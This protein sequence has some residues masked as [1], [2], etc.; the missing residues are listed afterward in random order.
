MGV[1]SR[2]AKDLAFRRALALSTFGVLGA[3]TAF[4]VAVGAPVVLGVAASGL[5]VLGGTVGL[6]LHIAERRAQRRD[7]LVQPGGL[8][9]A[10][11][12]DGPGVPSD[13]RVVLVVYVAGDERWRQRFGV[14]LPGELERVGRHVWSD[15][16]RLSVEPGW[17]PE[18]ERAIACADGAVVLVSSNLVA[19]RFV[20]DDELAALR[21]RG[22][23]LIFVPVGG[24]ESRELDGLGAVSWGCDPARPLSSLSQ[25]RAMS[26]IVRIARNLATQLPDLARCDGTDQAPNDQRERRVP[27]LKP[28]MRMG[29]L[30]DV[31]PPATGEVERGELREIC[32]ALVGAG[33]GSVGITGRTVGLYGQ[34]GIGKTVLAAAVARDPVV[35]RHFP[36][37][38]YWVT[39]GE[40][41]DIVER[42]LALLARLGAPRPDLRSRAATG[43]ALQEALAE[44]RCLLIGDDV[45]ST[46]DAA[47]F[48]VTDQA[49]QV[50]VLYTSRDERV[51]NDVDSEVQRIDV[52]PEATARGL[53]AQLTNRRVEALP[54]VTD[55]ILEATGRV[56]LAVALV[57]AAIGRGQRDWVHVAEELDFAATTF[58]DH[59]YADV[60]KAMQVALADDPW[61][62]ERYITLAVYPQDERV[63]IEAIARLWSHIKMVSGLTATRELLAELADANLLVLDDDAITFHDLQHEFLLLRIHDMRQAHSDLL[64]A[65]RALPGVAED[66]WRMLPTAEPYIWE[67]LLY[68]LHGAGDG[69]AVRAVAIDLAY[70]AVRCAREGPYAA[71]R[72]AQAAERLFADDAAIRWTADLLTRWGHLVAGHTTPNNVAAT[73]AIRADHPPAPIDVDRLAL[74]TN[75]FL[76]A[77][78]WGLPTPDALL[79]TLDE[80]TDAVQA[81][82]FSPDGLLLATASDDKTVLLWDPATGQKR[83]S[84]Q[85]RTDGVRALVFSPGG[86]LLATASDDSSVRLWNPA[87]GEQQATLSGHTR[88]VRA[89]AFSPDGRLLATASDD[90]TVRLWDPATGQQRRT[91][92][93]HASAVRAVTFS[94]DGRRLATASDDSTVRL[95]D[96]ATGQQWG[97]VNDHVGAVCAVDFSPDGRLLATAGEDTTVMLSERIWNA[98]T[99]P[100]QHTLHG[101]TGGVGS[102]AFS[103]D[104]QLLATASD[105]TTVGLWDPSDGR[106]HRT[107][108]GHARGVRAVA[109]S[110]DGRLLATASD[111]TT[112]RLWDP[113]SP[114]QH[115]ANGPARGVRAVALSRDARLLG[116]V[117]FDERV[118]LWDLLIAAH[119]RTFS[120]HAMEPRVVAFSPKAVRALA[121]SP[122]GRLLA[123][124]EDGGTIRLWDPVTGAEERTLTSAQQ[125]D[126]GHTYA[127][128]TLEVLSFSPDGRLL[129]TVSHVRTLRL[130]HPP[131]VSYDTALRL[132]DPATGQLQRT[133]NGQM[134][135]VR[136]VAFSPNGR[137]L[138]TVGDDSKVRLWDPATGRRQR[139]FRGHIGEV[140]AVAFS[141]DGRLLATAGD[142]TTVQLWHPNRR[143]FGRWSRTALGRRSTRAILRV[144][145]KTNAV[146][147]SPDGFTLAAAG[148]GTLALWDTR[149]R[150]P[151]SEPRTGTNRITWLTWTSDAIVIA[152]DGAIAI[153]DV[154][155]QR[156]APSANTSARRAVH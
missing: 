12:F 85:G 43:R 141:P 122:N 120:S 94:P 50:R 60:F 26:A 114:E 2:S 150:T 77:P 32:A 73:L 7:D 138:A 115:R 89:L 22:I 99:G 51:L 21:S 52:L 6:A 63:P 156:E 153:L 79:R 46:Q 15:R 33:R 131:S 20:I 53:L 68:H 88:A 111:D 62:A 29:A 37:G 119:P 69:S 34:G 1:K 96:P 35:R 3:G 8:A 18:L 4:A 95:W 64:D 30:H 97:A 121:L 66:G 151:I 54:T 9:A 124:A 125:R 27:G 145:Q 58:L 47:A 19:S 76:L 143:S 44:R 78:R 11:A 135:R 139:T 57:G 116:T 100:Q 81:L 48:D 146:A 134:G 130:W 128:E 90:K 55:R 98:A 38:V 84:L 86:R 132:W 80:H 152:T 13:A 148:D 93:G 140:R 106:R 144:G 147:F 155:D 113:A 92:N 25:V 149:T 154:I 82:A 83:R 74:L 102:L 75:G 16:R 123:T 133:L 61:L 17:H 49:P 127:Q 104:G 45:W 56:A 65:Y 142:D 70:L 10:S 118:Q 14:L 41:A 136:A 103:P 24:L 40:G 23:P 31:P 42:Q 110:P 28:G 107:L 71:S 117:G 108:S 112:V 67:H 39:V 91:I 101:R 59:P 129:A 105:D 72:D 109:F 36:D 87:T 126:E 5:A 137:L